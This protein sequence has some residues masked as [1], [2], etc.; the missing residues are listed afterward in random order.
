VHRRVGDRHA[1]E[2]RTLAHGR[3][4]CHVCADQ[5]LADGVD[6]RVAVVCERHRGGID[7]LDAR[8]DA[9]VM[10]RHDL[11]AVAE[12]D[13]VAVVGGR[14]VRRRDHDPGS[15]IELGDRPRQHGGGHLLVE[16]HRSDSVGRH[17]TRRVR[18]EH[19]TLAPGVVAD[20]DPALARIRVGVEEV[21]GEPGRGLTHDQPVHP[22]RAGPDRGAQPGGAEHQPAVETN[23]ELIRGSVDQLLK[24]LPNV[25]VGFGIQ[26]LPSAWAGIDVHFADRVPPAGPRGA[27]TTQSRARA[28][29]RPTSET[30]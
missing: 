17:H 18:G 21:L 27:P 11:S 15:R 2:F 19:V 14:V 12:V 4:R 10:G 7:A 22:E 29:E 28:T 26:P 24:L 8:R 1:A 9:D 23:G 20:H 25:G 30:I 5:F 13:L 16:Q 3:N 6:Q